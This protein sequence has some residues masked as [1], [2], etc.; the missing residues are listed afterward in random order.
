MKR[1][2]PSL[3][4]V[5][6]HAECETRRMRNTQNAKHAECETRRMRNTQNAN[7]KRLFKGYENKKGH[8]INMSFCAYSIKCFSLKLLVLYQRAILYISLDKAL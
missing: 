2:L 3:C 7:L 4:D 1:S 6:K 8:V 5:A